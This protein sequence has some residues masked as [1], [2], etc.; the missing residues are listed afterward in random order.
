MNHEKSNN[1]I[2]KKRVFRK[3]RKC[4]EEMV[5][6]FNEHFGK[7]KELPS[8]TLKPAI[9][10]GILYLGNDKSGIFYLGNDKDGR[11]LWLDKQ[12]MKTHMLVYGTTGSGKT[13]SLQSLA[14]NAFTLGTGLCYVDPKGD[15]KLAHELFIMA[16]RVSREDDFLT[17]DFMTGGKKTEGRTPTRFSNT[18]NP[19]SDASPDIIMNLLTSLLPFDNERNSVLH[20]KAVALI[21]ALIP[22]L[23][24][25]RDAGQSLPL[26][27]MSKVDGLMR[28]QGKTGFGISIATIRDYLD[29]VACISLVYP[30]K[31]NGFPEECDEVAKHVDKKLL[32]QLKSTLSSLNYVPDSGEPQNQESFLNQ[33]GYAKAYF[34]A[35]LASI[36]GMYGHLLNVS[37]GEVDMYDCLFNRRILVDI[38]PALE[39]SPQECEKL[40]KIIL[41]SVKN[42]VSGGLGTG[43]KGR[44][45][46]VTDALPA[47]SKT[48]SIIIADEYA[49]IMMPDF[50]VILTQARSL[51]LMVIIASQDYSGMK[52]KDSKA[53]DKI[54][55]NMAT[56]LFMKTSSDQ[57]TWDLAKSLTEEAN[58][59]AQ[60]DLMSQIEGEFH[61][62]NK[63]DV[64]RGTTQYMIPNMRHHNCFRI[65]RFIR[66][67]IDYDD[68]RKKLLE[69]GIV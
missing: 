26:T 9:A 40:G 56:K 33:F 51:G 32:D 45:K 23:C 57:E 60:G 59:I 58:K 19:F 6:I 4:W 42:S 28:G 30:L 24:A 50:E 44:T 17:L 38:L 48:P 18:T 12:D 69:C 66:T 41:T 47:S 29:P 35:P 61:A 15:P 1:D 21:T 11:E 37:N 68:I 27:D 8:K 49:A 20:Q 34:G 5:D 25:L 10:S 3:T 16:R 46:D 63:G 36:S 7:K 14:Y 67:K 55:E 65:N 13:V 2:R 64:I 62:I 43:L 53:C 39:K 31:K 22:V 52:G 54:V